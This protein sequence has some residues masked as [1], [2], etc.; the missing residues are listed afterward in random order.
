M[1]GRYTVRDPGRCLAEFSILENPAALEP[2]FNIAPSQGIWAVRI[3]PP[4]R[5]RRLHLLRW[6][7][8]FPRQGAWKETA[9]AR[10]ETVVMK[11]A[12]ADAFASR[13]CLLLADGFYEWRRIGDQSS[14]YYV[15]RPG[16]APFAMAGIW[17]PAPKS[18]H[19][20]AALPPLDGCAVITRPARPPVATFHDRMPALI[21]ARHHA[22]WLDPGADRSVLREM[23]FAEPEL[24]LLA[25]PVGPRVNS[26]ANDDDGCIAPVSETS[27]YPEQLALFSTELLREPAN[28]PAHRPRSPVR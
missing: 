14:A 8:A 12:F 15:H 19:D 2:R 10:A 22:A 6:G 24:D 16:G 7:F 18:A 11:S 1:C 3:V 17:Q 20:A 28:P 25:I 23:L 26:P 9:M 5:D 13:R 4:D 27:R 21:A